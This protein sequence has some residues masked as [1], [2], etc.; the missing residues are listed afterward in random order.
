MWHHQMKPEERHSNSVD[1]DAKSASL[2]P[3][4]ETTVEAV[5][6]VGICRGVISSQFFFFLN[7]SAKWI[8]QLPTVWCPF[9]E[10]PNGSCPKPGLGHSVLSTSKSFCAEKKPLRHTGTVSCHTKPVSF[11]TPKRPNFGLQIQHVCVCVLLLVFAV[12]V[13][14]SFKQLTGDI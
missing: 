10:S 13:E 7:N 4:N 5:T 14:M 12:V 3:R 9:R 11:H 1:G 6:F 2:A 8:S